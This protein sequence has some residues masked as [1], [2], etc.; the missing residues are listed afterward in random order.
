MHRTTFGTAWLA[1]AGGIPLFLAACGLN[2][3]DRYED[4][5]EAAPAAAAAKPESYGQAF[6]EVAMADSEARP[7]MH[8]RP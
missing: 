6:E 2:G 5:E 4:A 1:A 7:Q 8:V 3:T